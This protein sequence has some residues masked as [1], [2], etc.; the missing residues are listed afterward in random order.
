MTLLYEALALAHLEELEALLLHEPV[1]RH[2]GGLPE[3][4]AFRRRMRNMLAGPPEGSTELWL[5]VVV[6]D[7]AAG[8]LLGWLQATLHEGLAEVAFVYGPAHWGKGYARQGLLWLHSHLAQ[9]DGRPAL[10]ATTVPANLRSQSLLQRCGYALVD[11]ASA[12]P[13]HSYDPGDLVF[14]RRLPSCD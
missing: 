14:F 1:Y 7:G 12:P 8:P 9:F 4:E 5:N 13:L 2:I 6:R 11:P 3:P 10:W